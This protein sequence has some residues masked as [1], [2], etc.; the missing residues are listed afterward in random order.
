MP[1][2][3]NHVDGAGMYLPSS[4]NDKSFQFRMPFFKGLIIPYRYDDFIKKFNGN[5]IVKDI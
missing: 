4:D 5:P 2:E 3:I 1:I